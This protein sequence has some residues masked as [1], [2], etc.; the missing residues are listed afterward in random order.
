[1]N[2]L[3]TISTHAADVCRDQ[4][5]AEPPPRRLGRV[6]GLDGLRGLAVLLVLVFHVGLPLRGGGVGVDVFFVLSG[7]LITNLLLAELDRSGTICFRGFYAR[8]ARRL[9][10]ALV[11]MLVLFALVRLVVG[12]MLGVSLLPT[13][14]PLWRALAAPLLF[15]T[16]YASNIV[17][18]RGNNEALGSLTPTWSLAAEEQ[19][20]LVWPLVL[21]LLA[22]VGMT[23]WRLGGRRVWPL[24]LTAALTVVA[25][26]L[27]LYAHAL[28]RTHP[29]LDPYFNPFD[30]GAELLAGCAAAL[31]WRYRLAP[32]PLRWPPVGWIALAALLAV[33][34]RD[35]LPLRPAPGA[36]ASW[37]D[38]QSTYLGVALLAAVVL[39]SVAHHPDGDLATL[40]C[41]PPLRY[42]GR[43]SYGLYL[44]NLPAIA[45]T[46]ALMPAAGAVQAGLV[47]AAASLLLAA[48]CWHLIE[49]R[50]LRGG[51]AS[52]QRRPVPAAAPQES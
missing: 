28:P 32:R 10:P 12:P 49:A 23:R 3:S 51:H 15:P 36:S 14:A 34:A 29:T 26:G 42:L 38:T 47:A 33:A 35:A 46:R 13:R 50:V 27:A 18:M 44:F 1:M 43:I 9:L 19:F 22:K 41:V 16:V 52:R 37:L 6:P 11:L 20:Y 31:V 7:F 5:V 24:A 39:L 25:G 30:R 40:F 45:V 17:A 48:G 21:W 4:T 2:E 8:R